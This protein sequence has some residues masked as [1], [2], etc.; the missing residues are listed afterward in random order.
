MTLMI[1][2]NCG[3]CG[4]RIQVQEQRVGTQGKCPSCKEL[5]KVPNSNQK[6]E[7]PGQQI[8]LAQASLENILAEVQS[9]GYG[10]ILLTF[11]A[12]KANPGNVESL[13]VTYSENL[14]DQQVRKVLAH[15]AAMAE[16]TERPDL[17]THTSAEPY[18]F[19]G[20]QLGMSLVKFKSKYRR[21]ADG[22]PRYLPFS[23]DEDSQQRVEALADTLGADHPLVKLHK[24]ESKLNEPNSSLLEEPWH[25]S[26]GIVSC[27]KEY[28]FELMSGRKRETV[29]GVSTEVVVYRFI[30]DQL[31]QI[32]ILFDTR[33]YEMVESAFI[34]KYGA[35]ERE[36][37]RPRKLFWN[38]G[39]ST[40]ALFRGRISP[41]EHSQ[42]IFGH[43]SLWSKAS[44][45]SPSPTD[46]I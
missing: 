1:K 21:K 44:A 19:K 9:R 11:S 46:D 40:I 38:N 8:C 41:S 13:R 31:Y 42:V 3:H 12:P 43:D 39:V 28:P 45:N 25:R 14:S 33:D 30:E 37:K 15:V 35:T 10:G 29:A 18:D 23:S 24:S 6:S 2:F 7:E 16:K 36:S 17:P 34:Q 4:A 26:A 27:R 32:V 5:I 22:D 20:D